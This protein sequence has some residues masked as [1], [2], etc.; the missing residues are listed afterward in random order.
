MKP[1]IVDMKEMSDSTEVYNS[2]PNPFFVFFIYMVLGILIVALCWMYFSKIDISVKSNGMFRSGED[3]VDISNGV[4]GKVE[5]C[6]FS[7]GQYVKEG[8]VLLTLN[9]DSVDESIKNYEAELEN[10]N[11]RI[12]ILLAY[13]KCLDGDSS[14]FEAL[15]SNKYYDEFN[16]RRL[17]TDA[18]VNSSNKDVSGQKSQY[19]KTVNSI[20]NNIDEYE[21]RINKLK[22]VE[23]CVK[24]R[25]NTFNSKDSYY[26]SMVSSYVS[27]YD[28]AK[29]QYNNQIKEVRSSVTGLKKQL[30]ATKDTAVRK[31]LKSE[32]TSSQTKIET[33]K[34]EKKKALNNL[35]LQ[36]IA[37][38]EQQIETINT[39]LLSLQSNLDS[40]QAQVE[41]LNSTDSEMNENITIMTE[42]ENVAS[43]LLTYENK[44]TECENNL[45]NFDLQNGKCTVTAS[46]SGYI[47]QNTEIKQGS[48]IQEGTTICQILPQNSSGYYAEIYVGN[49]D[50]AKMKEGQNVKFEIAA[51]PSAEYGYFTGVV[52]SIS[53]DIKVDESSGS[54][55]YLVKVRCEQTIVTNK[56]GKTGTIMNGMACQAKVVVDEENVL[57]Y[58]LKKIDL[59]D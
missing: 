4:T 11:A 19:E 17:L 22:I 25:K 21:T 32:I 34:N 46:V 30:K 36:Q 26:S 57:E 47:S 44:K 31:E 2:R 1:I 55:Y 40:A 23:S 9:V 6:N 52:D 56:E 14:A 42:K 38:I 12:E 39:T 50:I 13:Q 15:K 49:A 27:N 41:A 35:E 7:E 43:E 45:N 37:T 18:N 54:A 5:K 53:K 51:Y 24:S 59:L 10:I 58:L 16:N 33:L 28:A 3:A 8:D 48:Y 29:L 20:Q